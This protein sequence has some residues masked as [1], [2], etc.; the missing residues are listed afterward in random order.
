MAQRAFPA[1]EPAKLRVLILSGLNNH[2]W[3]STTPVIKK[4][5]T[6][7]ARFG[8][9]DVTE[10][11]AGLNAATL[12]RYDVLVSNWTP[13]PETRRSWP[14]ET[15]AAFLDF[16]RKGGGFVVLHASACTFQGWP[17]FQQ[18]IALTWK[19]NHTAHGTYHTFK[20]SVEDR[21][22]PIAQGLTDFYTT[23]ELYHQMVQMA[24]QPLHVVFKAFSA[25]AEAGTGRDEPVLVC[26]ELGRGRGVNLVLGHDAAAMGAGFRTLLLRS[27]E[28]A[29][30]GQ[31]T[32]PPPAI[33]PSTPAAMTAAGIDL[34]STFERRRALPIRRRAEAVGRASATGRVCQQPGWKRP[35]GISRRL[36]RIGWWHC[37]LRRTRR[38]QPRVLSADNSATLPRRSTPRPCTASLL[39][40]SLRRTPRCCTLERVPGPAVDKMLRDALGTL[41]GEVRL[42]V[43]RALG[44]RRDRAAVEPLIALLAGPDETLAGAA[45]DALGRIDGSAAVE[46]L[47]EAL[48]R[49]KGRLRTE[50]AAACLTCADQ[51]LAEGQNAAAAALYRPLSGPGE[52][53]QVRMA[54]LRGTVRANP[55]QG[56]GA[57]CGALTSGDPALESMALQLVPELPGTAATEQL[58]QCVAEDPWPGSGAAAG[59]LGGSRRRGRARGGPGGRGQRRPGS[60]SRCGQGPGHS[61]RRDFRQAVARPDQC[62]RTNRR[63]P[64]GAGESHPSAGTSD[65]RGADR[66]SRP[67]RRQSASGVDPHPCGPQRGELGGGAR[68]ERRKRRMGRSARKRGRR[69]ATWRGLLTRRRCSN[70]C[71]AFATK[72]ETMPRGPW[73]PCSKDRTDRT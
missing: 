62:R 53:A 28:W 38:P 65:Q 30:T 52:T 36:W 72:T 73:A 31:V 40:S 50:V 71:F 9:V 43:V 60:P 51:L 21:A 1:G 64:G 10:D 13:Y 17:E 25:K 54:A 48:A 33:W 14:P 8:T 45:A 23:D 56:I 67:G 11:P 70:C 2:D 37:W 42:G 69:W 5:F 27:A 26:T 24:E 29:A 47:K 63:T 68:K 66:P 49:T 35:P 59:R 39:T 20:V 6:D 16:V 19:A 41:N 15:E 12:A 55:E 22:H 61:W 58:A 57:V 46:A 32:L 18:L 4:M 7:C 3:R 34:N 44:M